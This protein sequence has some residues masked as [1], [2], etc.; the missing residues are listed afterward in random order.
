MMTTMEATPPP[1]KPDITVVCGEYAGA[2]VVV[3][4]APMGKASTEE[5]AGMAV[6]AKVTGKAIEFSNFPVRD[7][8]I[9][10]LGTEEDVDEIHQESNYSIKQLY[11]FE[12]DFDKRDCLPRLLHRKTAPFCRVS[13]GD[14]LLRCKDNLLF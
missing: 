9:K 14:F 10:I 2:V 11:I 3:E 12:L 4:A 7:L 8:I 5:P 13:R 1:T 6:E